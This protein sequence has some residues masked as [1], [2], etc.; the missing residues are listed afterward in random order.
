MTT[1]THNRVY[2]RLSDVSRGRKPTRAND[3]FVRV[4]LWVLFAALLTFG[5]W[6]KLA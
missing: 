3:A 4:A 2:R 6:S 1:Y 5:L